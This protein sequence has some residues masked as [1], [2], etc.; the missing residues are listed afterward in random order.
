MSYPTR[1]SRTTALS[2]LFSALILLLTLPV[3][4]SAAEAPR[5][6]HRNDRWALIVDGKPFLIFGG[7]I[8]NSSAWPSELPQVWESMAELHANTLDAPVYWEQFEPQEG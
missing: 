4:A 7:Q 6:V 2:L 3:A 8:H 5:I 1:A